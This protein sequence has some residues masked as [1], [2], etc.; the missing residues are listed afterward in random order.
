[1]SDV[2]EDPDSIEPA[3]PAASTTTT[4][5]TSSTVST[6]AAA[7]LG[8]LAAM[9]RQQLVGMI[10]GGLRSILERKTP[11]YLPRPVL[12]PAA[13]L[14]RRTQDADPSTVTSPTARP[15]RR[16]AAPE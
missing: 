7:M 1:M 11:V 10:V 3:A 8:P 2:T 15:S 16:R 9:P 12:A 13:E 5:S 6:D 4:R 14:G